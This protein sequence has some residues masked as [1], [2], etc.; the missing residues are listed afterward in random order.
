MLLLLSG[1]FNK[2][3]PGIDAVKN[4][5][6]SPLTKCPEESVCFQSLDPHSASYAE[7]IKYT[8]SRGEAITLLKDIFNTLSGFEIRH[9]TPEYISVTHTSSLLKIKTTYEFDLRKLKIMHLRAISHAP[10][11]DFGDTLSLLEK[12]KFRFYQGNM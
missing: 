12:I 5:E 3:A 4:N 10:S 8:Q 7:P 1:C 6:R 11:Y 2:E 9:E